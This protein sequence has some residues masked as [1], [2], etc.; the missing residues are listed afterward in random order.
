MVRDDCA[1]RLRGLFDSA[2]GGAGGGWQLGRNPRE[3]DLAHALDGVAHLESIG[4][5]SLV[6]MLPAGGSG[7]WPARLGADQLVRLA[8]KDIR[9]EFD[10]AEAIQ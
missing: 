2:T 4:S 9:V 10:N 1:A 3:Q 8:D 5:L 6:E 7:P